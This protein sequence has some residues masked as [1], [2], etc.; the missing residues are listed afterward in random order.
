MNGSRHP[1]ELVETPEIQR[2]LEM[3]QSQLALYARDLKRAVTELNDSVEKF[4][5]I[6]AGDIFLQIFPVL[7]ICTWELKDCLFRYL[8]VMI[9]P[10]DYRNPFRA[11][12]LY[13]SIRDQIQF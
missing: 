12:I 10:R 11:G 5:S 9:A 4:H 8:Q 13:G 2:Q 1:G 6:A 7:F 3:A